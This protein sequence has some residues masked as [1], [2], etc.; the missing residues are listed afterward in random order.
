MRYKPALVGFASDQ[1][2]F[3]L[4]SKRWFVKFWVPSRAAIQVLLTLQI[5]GPSITW[6]DLITYT[7]F[8]HLC[9][10]RWFLAIPYQALDWRCLAVF[11]FQLRESLLATHAV[12]FHCDYQTLRGFGY[13]YQFHPFSCSL[14]FWV[15]Y[16]FST[17]LRYNICCVISIWGKGVVH[18]IWYHC[19]VQYS[20]DDELTI[21]LA[22]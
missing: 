17:Q 12:G 3:C 1:D 21:L 7:V 16:I 2:R 9:L 22:R 15:M 20:F 4:I 6:P 18:P 13:V 19:G 10:R 14:T 11:R 5:S 8:R